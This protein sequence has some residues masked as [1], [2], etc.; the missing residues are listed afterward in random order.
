[1]TIFWFFVCLFLG[2]GKISIHSFQLKNDK[3]YQTKLEMERTAE[4]IHNVFSNKVKNR[5]HW[6][7]KT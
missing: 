1:M 3:K 6:L 2:P 5:G 7:P 4:F